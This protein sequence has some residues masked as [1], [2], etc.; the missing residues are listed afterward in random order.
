[1]S[2]VFYLL[3]KDKVSFSIGKADTTEQHRTAKENME[4]R[5]ITYSSRNN[6]GWGLEWPGF[7]DADFE[8]NHSAFLPLDFPLDKVHK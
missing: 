3:R 6:G 8:V 2:F 1:M 4:E 5:N 7:S